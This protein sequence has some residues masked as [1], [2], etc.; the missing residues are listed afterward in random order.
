MWKVYE[1]REYRTGATVQICL[2]R[3]A[4]PFFDGKAGLAEVTHW[5]Y[6]L[7]C[8][9]SVPEEDAVRIKGKSEGC[10]ESGSV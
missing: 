1:K 4:C 3:C 6:T 2:K 8:R 7:L 5:W 9:G 10:Y